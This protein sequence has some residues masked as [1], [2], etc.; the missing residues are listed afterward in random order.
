MGYRLRGDDPRNPCICRLGFAIDLDP[1]CPGRFR[2]LS[3]SSTVC[4]GAKLSHFNYLPRPPSDSNAVDA[5]QQWR[6][7]LAI[8]RHV[9]PADSLALRGILAEMEAHGGAVE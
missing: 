4:G 3:V 7:G 2:T 9:C 8:Y 1:P 5:G 6:R